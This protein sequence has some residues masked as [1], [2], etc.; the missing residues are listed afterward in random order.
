MIA[1]RSDGTRL[2]QPDRYSASCSFKDIA[3]LLLSN[4]L[5][6]LQE[7][8]DQ[9]I[10]RNPTGSPCHDAKRHRSPRDMDR[11]TVWYGQLDNAGHAQESHSREARGKAK[12]QQ[13]WEDDF[14]RAGEEGHH[15]GRRK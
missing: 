12:D 6:E 5:W 7:V 3:R 9:V 8:P 10:S 13:N 4:D 1:C 14:A 2:Y 15:A 11:P